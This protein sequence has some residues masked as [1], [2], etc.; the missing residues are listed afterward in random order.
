[1][2]SLLWGWISFLLLDGILSHA[3]EPKTLRYETLG[4]CPISSLNGVTPTTYL[5]GTM[6]WLYETQFTAS[7]HKYGGRSLALRRQVAIY[8]NDHFFLSST[9]LCCGVYG[10]ECCIWITF[11]VHSW[12]NSLLM[13]SHP[14]SDISALIFFRR[15]FSSKDLKT[16]KV[17]NTSEFY[18]RKWIQ[19]YL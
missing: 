5:W 2:H 1:M 11:E 12:W 7:S 4:L 17:S 6:F 16:L 3:L 10:N 19:E 18:L 15:V 8:F 13:H 14:L 9:P